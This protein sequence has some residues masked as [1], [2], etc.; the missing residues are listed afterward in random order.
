[1]PA[2][3]VVHSVRLPVVPGRYIA[4]SGAESQTHPRTG[5]VRRPARSLHPG[6]LPRYLLEPSACNL[7][8]LQ[9]VMLSDDQFSL[10]VCKK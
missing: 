3:V 9:A 6:T 8:L 7:H 2:A 5:A 4:A 1:M 10:S